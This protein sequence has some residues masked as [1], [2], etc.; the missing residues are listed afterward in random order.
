MKYTGKTQAEV[1]AEKQAQG[2]EACRLNRL[3]AYRNE[4]D[5]LYMKWQRGEATQQEWLDKIDEIKARF[6]KP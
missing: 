4:S 3:E 5:P 1:D 2:V 6:P